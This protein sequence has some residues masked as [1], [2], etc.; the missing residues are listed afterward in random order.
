MIEAH[1]IRDTPLYR[2][3]MKFFQ[4]LHA[5]G[6]GIMTDA[7]DL[8]VASDGRKAAFTGTV[9]RD[10]DNPPCTRIGM[11]SLESG[12]VSVCESSAGCER[13]PQFSPDGGSLAYLSDR[14]EQGIFQLY[15]V[16][17]R[18]G[19]THSAPAITGVI[20]T[21]SW[22]ADGSG[23]LVSVAGFGADIAGVQGGAT[24]IRHRNAQPAWFPEVD[25]G[26]AENLWRVAYVF[27]VATKTFHRWSPPGINV[28]ECA[29]V[30]AHEI[31]CIASD[32]HSEGSWYTSRLL[33]L[34]S[35]GAVREV[36]QSDDQLGL[37]VASP[38]GRRI[39]VIEAVCSDRLM[40]CGD[41]QLLSVADGS[42]RK[43][44]LGSI[45]VTQMKW[46]D[47]DTLTFVGLRG[48]DTVIGD[49]SIKN[50]LL[51]ER[52]AS[53]E[54]TLGTTY[55]TIELMPDGSVLAI[56][57][58]YSVPPQIVRIDTG[59]LRVLHSFAASVTA[60]APH[61]TVVE[62]LSWNGRDGMRI[63]GWLVKPAGRGPFPLVMDIH[64]GPV[65]SAR[66]R[67]HGRLRGAQILADHGIAS[68]Y[69]NPRGSS[70]RGARFARLVKGDMGGE[71]AHDCLAGV[72]ALVL[73]G[74][75]DPAKLGVTGISY[76][77]YLSA[78]LGDPGQS[79]RS[80]GSHI[81]RQQLV[82]PTSL[83][84]NSVLRCAVFGRSTC[85]P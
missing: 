56:G 54:C 3:V 72:D 19:G 17:L 18:G 81:A 20:E 37:P 71:D 41:I 34:N 26:N 85:A 68:F 11:L 10:F 21:L 36:Y 66:N 67:W 30:N 62:P 53:R 64:G 38:F 58:S 51:V 39:A 57:E 33:V 28:W 77:G 32:S 63:E 25:S 50:N 79:F 46:R 61:T 4:S 43:L 65:W 80:G 73:N 15:V 42:A 23:L 55:P 74:I 45:D 5:P 60:S 31:V 12:Q 1:D 22:S 48:L 7:S 70:G 40:V 29:W 59:V 6:R 49:F 35:S 78:W 44:D 47:E 75:A 16:D 8:S 83:F 2:E 27:D 82:Q 14:G 13:L 69:P 84:S 24:T 9:F 76:G 52:W